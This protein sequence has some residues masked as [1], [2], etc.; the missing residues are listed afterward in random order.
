[1]NPVLEE[2]LRTREVVSD[3]G[4]R[5]PLRDEITRDEGEFLQRIIYTIKPKVSLEIGLAHGI[6]AMFIC[7]ALRKIDARKHI[8]M[9][10]YQHSTRYNGIGLK[11]LRQAGY[12]DLIDFIEEPSETVL[13]E[14]LKRKTRI[15]FAFVDGWHTFDHTLVDFFYINMMLNI[16]GVVAFDDADWQS[17]SKL[18]RFISRYPCYKFFARLP[19]KRPKRKEVFIIAETIFSG[20]ITGKEHIEKDLNVARSGRCIAFKKEKED[21]R[22]WLWH[23]DF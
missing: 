5:L 15:D 1:M 23:A 6:S 4:E 12:E 13:P 16:G 22:D 18:C 10:P 9:D 8:V 21:T 20:L 17:I 3:Q 2:V 11:N 7:D 19:S 14:L